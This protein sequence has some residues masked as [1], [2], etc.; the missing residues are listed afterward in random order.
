VWLRIATIAVGV[1]LIAAG[2]ISLR[3]PDPVGGACETGSDLSCLVIQQRFKGGPYTE[4]SFSYVRVTGG[5]EEILRELEGPGSTL[6]VA[7]IAV[8]PGSYEIT[9]FQRPCMGT[10]PPDGPLDPARDECA[11][12]FTV[13]AGAQ[14]TAKIVVKAGAGCTISLEG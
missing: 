7:S 12:S 9:S 8:E 2:V 10:C 11:A 4:G 13:K 3:D 1:M 14:F 5:G 6:R